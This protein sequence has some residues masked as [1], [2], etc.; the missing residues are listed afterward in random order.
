MSTAIY[1]GLGEKFTYLTAHLYILFPDK[2]Q[3]VIW[4]VN[5][6]LLQSGSY[7]H[8]QNKYLTKTCATSKCPLI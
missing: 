3:L 2:W 8:S 7:L 5:N 1:Y 4:R 6:N